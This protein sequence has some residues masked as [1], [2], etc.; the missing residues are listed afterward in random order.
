MLDEARLSCICLQTLHSDGDDVY[1]AEMRAEKQHVLPEW[2]RVVFSPAHGRKYS[3]AN[4]VVVVNQSYDP[5][6]LR[7]DRQGSECIVCMR[8][9]FGSS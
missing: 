8:T 3:A 5:S 6:T 7:I 2:F 1:D 9:P 4:S